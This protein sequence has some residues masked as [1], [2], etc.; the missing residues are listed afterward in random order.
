MEVEMDAIRVLVVDDE[1]SVVDVLRALIGS[2]PT[3]EFAGAAGDAERGIE[4][5]LREQPDVVLMDV[6]M[7]GGGGVRAVREI[8]KRSSR[9]KVVALSAHED[10]D[11][12][13]R[14]IGAGA[15]AY[16]PKSESTDEILRAIHRSVTDD[17]QREPDGRDDGLRR[18]PA[19]RREEQRARVELALQTGAVTTVFQAIVELESGRVIGVEAQPRVAMLPSRPYDAW[20]A[21]AE[22]TGLLLDVELAAFR[23]ALRALERLPADRF[24]E[25]E[26][27]PSTV[28]ATTFQKTIR[29]SAAGRLV[30]GFSE[31]S[32]VHL[33]VDDAIGPLRD[34]GV[35]FSVSDAGADL[36]SLDH[37][38][39]LSPAFVRIDAALTDHVERDP[40]RHAVVATVAAW[41]IEA[42][43]LPVA[44]RVS[45]QAQL[46]ELGRLGVRCVQGTHVSAPWH[47]SELSRKRA[48]APMPFK[49]GPA[50]A[51]TPKHNTSPPRTS[52]HEETP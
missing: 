37:V 6:R 11:T 4:L 19:E 29:R 38:V 30:L 27:S 24:L 50:T 40:S 23:S 7:P 33:G 47:L 20:C 25:F 31:L 46:E 12:M 3:L 10:A 35:R 2:D 45:T 39:R 41:T 43:A 32:P 5:A 15:G 8:R 52:D 42:G 18:A 49:E 14:M 21:D 1:E 51:D 44:E 17:W 34:R 48:G 9:T 26:V 13:I 36:G 22:A 16:V 28:Q